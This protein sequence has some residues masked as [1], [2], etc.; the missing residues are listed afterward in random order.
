V[1]RNRVKRRLRE[2]F[3]IDGQRFPDGTDVVVVALPGAALLGYDEIRKQIL[4]CLH[5]IGTRSRR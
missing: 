4:D 3:R 5:R 1:A 2:I